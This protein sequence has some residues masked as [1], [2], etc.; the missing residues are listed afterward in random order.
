MTRGEVERFAAWR[1]QQHAAPVVAAVRR[2][3]EQLRREELARF[4]GTLSAEEHARLDRLTASLLS[5]LLHGPCARLRAASAEPDGA[6]HVETFRMLFDVPAEGG[7][8]SEAD[9]I[10]LPRRGAA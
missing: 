1:G 3:A 2:Q 8:D 7:G 4:A 10:A 5:K 6:A 9:V